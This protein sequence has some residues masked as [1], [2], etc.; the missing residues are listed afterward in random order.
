MSKSKD[1]PKRSHFVVKLLLSGQP[2]AV[3]TFKE[4]FVKSGHE[5]VFY[6]LSYYLLQAKHD[7]AIIKAHRDGKRVS[8]Y[9]LINH[10]LFDADGKF[11]KPHT[12]IEEIAYAS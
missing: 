2:V 6:K 1:D 9:Q 7:G 4:E 3:E 10:K 8:A 5:K 11:I 12:I